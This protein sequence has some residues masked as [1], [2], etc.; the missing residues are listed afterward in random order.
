MELTAELKNNGATK[1]EINIVY[2]RASKLE[3]IPEIE[4]HLKESKKLYREVSLE[5]KFVKET[6]SGLR[7][8]RNLRKLNKVR[9]FKD[10][11][12]IS[13]NPY[14][15]FFHISGIAKTMN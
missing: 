3:T 9:T 10:L 2:E 6:M 8:K 14:F 12:I 4:A 15:K 13:K 7:Q 5:I 11:E 1:L